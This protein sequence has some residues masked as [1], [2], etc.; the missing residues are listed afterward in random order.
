MLA[1]Q[2]DECGDVAQAASFV[3]NDMQPVRQATYR[4]HATADA[5]DMS[6]CRDGTSVIP[7]RAAGACRTLTRLTAVT[8][9][10]S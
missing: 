6:R 7:Y 1:G 5:T 2:G 9:A 3:R 4:H 10:P 8:L